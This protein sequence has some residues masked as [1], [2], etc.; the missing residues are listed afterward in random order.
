MNPL[1][2]DPHYVFDP[3]ED[4]KS[5]ISLLGV[6]GSDKDIVEDARTSYAKARTEEYT[7]SDAKLLRYLLEH[8]HTSPLRGSVMKFRVT[9]PLFVCRQWWKHTIASTHAEEQ[10]GWNEQSFRYTEALDSRH[11]YVPES[12]RLQGHANKQGSG[13]NIED[14]VLA[15][16]A[17]STYAN[18][19]DSSYEAY[20]QLIEM[21]VSRELAR[22]VLA[23][24][25][26]TT[27]IWTASLQS[28]L[29]FVYL[30]RTNHAQLEIREYSGCVEICLDD[31][32]PDTWKAFKAFKLGE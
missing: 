13:G 22:G 27:W 15:E 10:V 20:A 23:P 24:A 29:N 14:P 17:F 18:Q 16:I 3:L 32:F 4:G 5:H 8:D 7:A 12:F 21:G 1:F 11:Y 19:C 2:N 30:R 9:A 6:L 25:F 31:W 26:Y 28:I